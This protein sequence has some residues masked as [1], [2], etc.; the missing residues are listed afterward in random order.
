MNII[1]NREDLIKLLKGEVIK[2]GEN[3][4]AL[5]DIGYD[6]INQDLN[7]IIIEWEQKYV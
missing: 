4:I 7:D 5:S 3:N 2:K 6:I 1:I